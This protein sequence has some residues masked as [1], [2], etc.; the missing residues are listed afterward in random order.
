MS[1][2]QQ[3]AAVV[4]KAYDAFNTA[5]VA[6]LMEVFDDNVTW[7]TPGR[8]SIGG[9]YQGKEATLGQLGRFVEDTGGSF[10]ALL[11]DVT[12][13]DSGAVISIHRNTAERNGK[14][15]DVVC[16]IVFDVENGKITS[17]RENF[18]DLYAWDEF[19]S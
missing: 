12:W 4:R 9:D 10:K 11:Q 15:L 2:G 6:M 5:D 18:F 3:N 14:Q 8:S 7:R 13:S 19:W 1:E 17:G 16:C